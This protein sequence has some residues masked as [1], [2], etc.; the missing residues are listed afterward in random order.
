[1]DKEILKQTFTDNWDKSIPNLPFKVIVKEDYIIIS[2]RGADQKFEFLEAIYP[3][4]EV[5]KG[6]LVHS[7]TLSKYLRLKSI[8][9]NVLNKN[10]TKIIKLVS[11]SMGAAISEILYLDLIREG[12]NVEAI[13]MNPYK[14]VDS[15]PEKIYRSKKDIC[16]LWPFWKK[17]AYKRFEVKTPYAFFRFK[18]NHMYLR[19]LVEKNKFLF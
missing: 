2:I 8:I 12:F 3:R 11:F 13:L 6:F 1:M 9:L 14:S 17:R 5:Y 18:K 19:E 4:Y 15:F 10:N 7:R 16:S